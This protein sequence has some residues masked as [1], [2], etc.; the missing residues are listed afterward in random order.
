MRSWA[1]LADVAGW[2]VLETAVDAARERLGTELVASY[3]LGSLAHGGFSA[4]TSDVDLALILFRI[5]GAT[6]PCMADIRTYVRARFGT[7]L[8]ERLSL[9]WSTW[10]DLAAQTPRGRFP[11]VDRIDLVQHGR[12]IFGNDERANV[13]LPSPS[14]RS[15]ELVIETARFMLAKLATSAH[16]EKLREP[17][18]LVSLGARDV[19]KA[20]L[21][22]ARFLFTAATG[23]C[24]G[25]L[26]AAAFMATRPPGAVS[27]LVLAAEQWRRTGTVGS[28][29]AALSQLNAGL[30]PLY[31]ELVATFAS[32]LCQ[33][34]EIRLAAEMDAWSARLRKSVDNTE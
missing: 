22:P 7:P 32:L 29:R 6:D 18:R 13:A 30:M 14:Q 24:A 3:A 28:E 9:F 2:E 17:E 33:H 23:R 26:E 11:L 12:C 20:V 21:L 31:F 19:T 27:D 34:G 10:S 15:C 8:S 16:E 25:N 1:Q 4:A 5:D